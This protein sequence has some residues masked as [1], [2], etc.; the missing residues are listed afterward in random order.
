MEAARAEQDLEAGEQEGTGA[1]Q[2]GTGAEQRR[3]GK[4]SYAGKSTQ[5]GGLE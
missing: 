3:A 2:E 1:E 5:G 4:L